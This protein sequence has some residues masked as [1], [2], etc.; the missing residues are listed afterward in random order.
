[1]DRL[2]VRLA[3]ATLL[4]F[5]P[6]CTGLEAMVSA[7]QPLVELPPDHPARSVHRY[8]ED[9]T[10]TFDAVIATLETMKYRIWKA[11][12][13]F[14]WLDSR[15]GLVVHNPVMVGTGTVLINGAIVAA[16]VLSGSARSSIPLVE[17]ESEYDYQL[18]VQVW[19][20]PSDHETRVRAAFTRSSTGSLG[21]I[22]WQ[23]E[24]S[25]AQ[26][27]A[28]FALLDVKLHAIGPGAPE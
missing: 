8:Q 26:Y 17:L 14:G 19:R 20:H 12:A 10:A 1:M 23:D 18:S 25:P 3:S 2:L 22:R 13:E 7:P 21:T 5:T 24:S 27:D 4:T 11:N 28:F 16:V 15:G 9:P 6:G